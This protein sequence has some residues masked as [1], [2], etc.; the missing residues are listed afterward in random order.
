MSPLPLTHPA[1][2]SMGERGAA[3][4]RSRR[5]WPWEAT[6][7]QV[8]PPLPAAAVVRV[9]ATAVAGGRHFCAA[10]A[11]F[12]G[13]WPSPVSPPPMGGRTA[14]AY[15]RLLP[16]RGRR[17]SAASAHRLPLP[18]SRGRVVRLLSARG[19]HSAAVLLQPTFCSRTA[20]VRGCCL[21]AAGGS[22]VIAV[23]QQCC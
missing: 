9:A 19:R 10:A 5:Q 17:L 12:T 20:A 21:H 4:S 16:V 23:M 7:L 15:V 1:A 14:A 6:A 11:A 8:L 3:S 2:T 22:T 18:H 13:G